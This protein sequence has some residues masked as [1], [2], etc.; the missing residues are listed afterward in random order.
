M[1]RVIARGWCSWSRSGSARASRHLLRHDGPSCSTSRPGRLLPAVLARHSRGPG[2]CRDHDSGA[3]ASRGSAHGFPSVG[4]T[5]DYHLVERWGGSRG[6]AHIEVTTHLGRVAVATQ[7]TWPTRWCSYQPQV[8]PLPTSSQWFRRFTQSA[9]A[10]PRS[11]GLAPGTSP[12][13]ERPRDATASA[14]ASRCS[15]RRNTARW[16]A[17]DPARPLRRRLCGCA[18]HNQR[19]GISCDRPRAGRCTRLPL[20]F[21]RFQRAFCAVKGMP[22]VTRAV[23]G[24]LAR[25]QT[26]P[27]RAHHERVRP[28]RCRARADH[29]FVE[30]TASALA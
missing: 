10:L 18:P 2:V 17:R 12:T 4:G 6:H 1:R 19:T 13:A 27:Q 9:I 28:C 25:A 30:I 23:E 7:G 15:V 24:Y 14:F 11:T 16:R 22:T 8:A 21:G 3:R 20:P 5:D 29:S 26:I